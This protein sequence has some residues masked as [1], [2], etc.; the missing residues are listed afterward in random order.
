MPAQATL[1]QEQVRVLLLGETQ[2]LYITSKEVQPVNLISDA[3][4]FNE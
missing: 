2:L 3:A 4:L 1:A